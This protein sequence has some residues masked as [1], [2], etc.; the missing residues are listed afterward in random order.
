MI[1][2]H[3]SKTSNNEASDYNKR[4]NVFQERTTR[5]ERESGQV[6]SDEGCIDRQAETG[7]CQRMGEHLQFRES[8]SFPTSTINETESTWF[9]KNPL[10]DE[11]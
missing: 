3:L 10:N 4:H 7:A 9:M 1:R 8:A 6:S 11:S 2:T 5:R